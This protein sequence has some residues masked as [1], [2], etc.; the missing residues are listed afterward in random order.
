M[1]MGLDSA[2]VIKAESG[3]DTYYY[4]SEE[5]G[6]TTIVWCTKFGLYREAKA[7]HKKLQESTSD[8]LKNIRIV[9]CKFEEV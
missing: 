5:D 4:D 9:K 7:V 3:K 8:W 1:R 6:W 2:Y